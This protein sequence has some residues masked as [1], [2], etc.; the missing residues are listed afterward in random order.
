M[1]TWRR[2]GDNSSAENLTQNIPM[3]FTKFSTKLHHLKK[4]LSDFIKMSSIHGVNNL[5]R[6]FEAKIFWSAVIVVAASACVVFV[7]QL[8]NFHDQNQ[9]FMRIEDKIWSDTEVFMEMFRI[10][11]TYFK[12]F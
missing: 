11:T 5:S 1:I 4:D 6:G 10:W 2:A 8:S 3:I 12:F 9:V 7:R